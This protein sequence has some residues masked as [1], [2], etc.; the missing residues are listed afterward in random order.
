MIAATLFQ[1]T[2]MLATLLTTFVTGFIL[3]FAIVIMPGLA[4]LPAADFLRAFQVIDRVIQNNQPLFIFIWLGSAASL[5]I[6]TILGFT[7]LDGVARLLLISAALSFIM[8]TQVPTGVVNIPLNNH[9]QSL[10]I[11]T[12]P[13][14]SHLLE[15]EHFE[16]R[17][18]RWNVLRALFATSSSVLLIVVLRML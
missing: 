13:E 15:R 8:G 18:N 4:T 9:V 5:V 14:S 3:L 12:M 10:A 17:W 7:Q 11:D 16:S 6:A 1:N 2:L